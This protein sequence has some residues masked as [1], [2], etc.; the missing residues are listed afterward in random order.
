MS[1]LFTQEGMNYVLN[2]CFGN[3]TKQPL[4]IALFKGNAEPNETWTASNFAS[5]A[6]EVVSENEGFVGNRPQW[7]PQDT[8]NNA[9]DNTQNRPEFVM[10]TTSGNVTITGIALLTSPNRGGTQGK[11]IAVEKLPA[12]TFQ[13]GDTYTPSIRLTLS[14]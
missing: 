7:I 12:R 5:V 3:G 8:D 14:N 2:T 4:Y 1:L 10:K 9:I 13:D 6:D 11:L